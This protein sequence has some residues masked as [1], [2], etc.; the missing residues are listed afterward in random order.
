MDAIEDPLQQI[1]AEHVDLA[2]RSL[3]E[4]FEELYAAAELLMET[5]VSERRILVCGNGSA[6]ALGQIFCAS[7]LSA[8]QLERPGLPAFSLGADQASSGAVLEQFNADEVFARQIRALGQPGDCL[9]II[10]NPLSR[11]ENLLHAVAAAHDRDMPVIAVSALHAQDLPAV[12]TEQDIELKVPGADPARVTECQLII[13]N[14]LS[15]V[16]E[17]QL[18]GTG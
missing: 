18:F 9:V 10:A 8:N 11:L 12:M 15:A 13:L 2:Y 3:D 7:L 1:F 4:M 5:L 16:I 14:A 6:G 17:Q